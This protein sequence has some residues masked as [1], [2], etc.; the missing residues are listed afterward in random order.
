[1]S[2]YTEVEQPLLQQLAAQGWT[3][4]DQGQGVPQLAAASGRAHFRQWWL[5]QVFREAVSN[6]NVLGDGTPWLTPAQLDELELQFQRHPNR[7]LIEANQ[8]VHQ[9]LMKATVNVNQATGE[10]D[11]V[12]RLVDFQHPQR[13]RFHAVNQFRLDPPGAARDFIIP[14]VVLFVNGLPWVVVE[15]KKGSTVCANPMQEAY[16]QLRRYMGQRHDAATGGQREGEP[17][18]FHANLLAVRTSGVTCGVSAR[19]L[20]G[21]RPWLLTQCSVV[22]TICSSSA[23]SW[24]GARKSCSQP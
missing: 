15:C 13:N 3:L 8:A 1:M 17:R 6:L 24:S 9:W 19:A 18:L 10:A 22:S 23:Q 12:V 21:E 5:P 11:P 2:E 14:D 16:E 4:I 20:P 7:S